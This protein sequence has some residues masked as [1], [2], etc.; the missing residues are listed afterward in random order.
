MAAS[1]LFHMFT[2]SI[3]FYI[4]LHVL[5]ECRCLKDVTYQI[6]IKND[7][8]LLS[9]SF[10]TKLG[11]VFVLTLENTFSYRFHFKAN[12]KSIGSSKNGTKDPQ[13][14]LQFERLACF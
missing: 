14:S 13:N 12:R 6:D 9:V 11:L 8:L 5:K 2:Q 1:D 3:K 4:S 7:R 10:T